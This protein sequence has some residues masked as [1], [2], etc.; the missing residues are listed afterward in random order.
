VAF[1]L[2]AVSLMAAEVL[3]ARPK[4]SGESK[5]TLVSLRLFPQ[6]AKLLGA[7]GSQRFVVLG[8]FSDGLERD[9]TTSASFSLK[10]PSLAALS[11][12]GKVTARADG[13]T[14]IAVELDGKRAESKLSV[15]ETT[16]VSQPLRA[17]LRAS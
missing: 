15:Q 17:M 5:A 16:T 4:T 12:Q 6:E 3:A 8:K 9:V 11:P 1:V 14:V 13:E 7:S 2:L 10:D